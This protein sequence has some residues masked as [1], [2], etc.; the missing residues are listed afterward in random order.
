MFSLTV[1][2]ILTV[3]VLSLWFAFPI[4]MFI[5]VMRQ[6]KDEMK[7]SRFNETHPEGLNFDSH[8]SYYDKPSENDIF[9]E[10]DIDEDEDE[11]EYNIA[12]KPPSNKNNH[13]PDIH[14]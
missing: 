11:E 2:Q 1:E 5:A 3:S 9:G 6:Q 4:G 14:I 7:N 10:D 13:Q 12:Y 8:I